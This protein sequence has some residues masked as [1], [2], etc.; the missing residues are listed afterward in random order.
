MYLDFSDN[1]KNNYKKS[2]ISNTES[3]LNPFIKVNIKLN[4]LKGK[5]NEFK[6]KNNPVENKKLLKKKNNNYKLKDN[7]KNL[8][9]NKKYKINKILL[10]QK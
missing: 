2:H 8:N 7:L 10:I 3:N 1:K 4:N 5:G 9:E 6:T